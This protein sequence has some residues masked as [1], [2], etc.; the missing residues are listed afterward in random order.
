MYSQRGPG[1]SDMVSVGVSVPLQW[2]RANRQEREVAARLATLEQ[3][4]A[5]RE[6]AVRAYRSEVRAMLLEWE[7]DKDRRARF[8]NE[9]LPLAAERTEAT[10]AAYRGARAGLTDVMLARRNEIDVR[11]QA[12]QLEG[13]MARAWAR[14]NF[15]V[16]AADRATASPIPQHAP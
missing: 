12:L 3:A 15:L 11:L 2:D 6:D 7:N 5:E 1:F 8:D 14:L 4:R 13:E 10:L 16:A 9:L